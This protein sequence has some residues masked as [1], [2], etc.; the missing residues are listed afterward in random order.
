[1]RQ[2]SAWSLGLLATLG[3]TLSLGCGKSPT[4]L[5]ESSLSADG[6]GRKVRHVA[7]PTI[8]VFPAG[9]EAASETWMS[10]EFVNTVDVSTTV[11]VVDRDGQTYYRRGYLLHALQFYGPTR[12]RS[13]GRLSVLETNGV[14]KDT[15]TVWT[16]EDSVAYVYEAI[17]L[18]GATPD[19]AAYAAASDPPPP[20]PDVDVPPIN[21]DNPPSLRTRRA[22]WSQVKARWR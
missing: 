22:S 16:L 12:G 7:K 19:E 18:N 3:L 15:S 1:M 20:P 14:L 10:S 21:F 4:D 9:G 5:T 11:Q 2:Q 8:L 6:N 13:I 17:D